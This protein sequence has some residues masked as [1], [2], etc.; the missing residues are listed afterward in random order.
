MSLDS[1]DDLAERAEYGV[2][3]IYTAVLR[4]QHKLH[5]D[6]PHGPTFEQIGI[7][8]WNSLTPTQRSKSLPTLLN[9]YAITVHHEERAQRLDADARDLTKTYLDDVDLAC[10]WDSV[11]SGDKDTEYVEATRQCLINVLSELELLQHRLAMRDRE[12]A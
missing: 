4:A 1:F 12:A 5:R 2:P 11:F 7:E 6:Y 3:D 8:A 10:L 9:Y